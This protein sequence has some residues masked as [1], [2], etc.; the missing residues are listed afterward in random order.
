MKTTKARLVFIIVIVI[1]GLYFLL[2]VRDIISPF[3]AGAV[4]AYLLSPAVKWLQKKGLRR[5]GAVAVIF[6]W[7]SFLMIFIVFMVLPLIYLEIGKLA[8]VLPDRLQVINN[9]LE[10]LKSNY[11]QAGL[12]GEVNRLIDEQILRSQDMLINW[13]ENILQ[14]LPSI[15]VSIGLLVLSPILAI[16]FLLDWPRITQS[17]INL[18][19]ARVRGEWLRLLQEIDYLIQRYIQGNIID[20]LIVGLLIGFGVKIVGMEYALLI[21]VI[22][23]VTNLI[24]Y[25]GPVLGT[26]PSVLLALGKSPL[27]SLK[28]LLVII[29]VQQLDS[30]FINPYLMSNK[31]GLHPLWVVFAL[32]AG[33]EIGGI[34]GMLIAIP[35]AAVLRIIFRHIY[36][37]L[38]SP[39]ELKTTKN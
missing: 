21:G 38:V 22:C 18:V 23:G 29:I 20:A 37:Y 13:L 39:R 11:T 34:F 3:V 35:L 12:P 8:I 10:N 16:Y 27:M 28:V 17:I 19:P 2:K 26:V 32:L 9:Y 15:L 25:F 24:P 5:K 14:N 1:I 33:G 7:I 6:I 30:N 31:L 4:L 36:Y